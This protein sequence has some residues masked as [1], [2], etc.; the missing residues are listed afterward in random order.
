M[1][2]LLHCSPS[3]CGRTV[4]VDF[5][6]RGG[7]PRTIVGIGVRPCA[8]ATRVRQGVCG[9]VRRIRVGARRRSTSGHGRHGV[10]QQADGAMTRQACGV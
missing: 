8:L 9:G 3:C 4:L 2:P 6:G 5:D 10:L 1:V 7:I